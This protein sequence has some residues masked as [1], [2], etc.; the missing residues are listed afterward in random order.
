MFT[1]T[2]S[3]QEAHQIC[4]EVSE[5]LKNC[6]FLLR[7]WCSNNPNIL[8]HVDQSNSAYDILE[9]TTENK[10]ETLGLTWACLNDKLSYNINTS[11]FGQKI[12]PTSYCKNI[13][14]T[15]SVYVQFWLKFYAEV[16]VWKNLVRCTLTKSSPNDMGKFRNMLNMLLIVRH[17]ILANATD[18]ELHGFA[19][20]SERAYGACVYLRNLDGHGLMQVSLLCAKSI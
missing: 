12:G 7:K 20:S 18:Y 4:P 1:G 2:N 17:V 3:I 8:K 16:M 9:L 6:C 10:T 13:W 11:S 19:D 14:F 5:V 15:W